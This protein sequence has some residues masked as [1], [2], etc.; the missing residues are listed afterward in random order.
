MSPRTARRLRKA[1]ADA[2]S[3]IGAANVQ[4]SGRAR[5]RYTAAEGRVLVTRIVR[6]AIVPA[7]DALTRQEP[8]TGMMLCSSG[9]RGCETAR[10]LP[11][12]RRGVRRRLERLDPFDGLDF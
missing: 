4:P 3:A 10:I 11:A 9:L 2:Q 8:H 5:L 7:K 6:P 1:R 12:L